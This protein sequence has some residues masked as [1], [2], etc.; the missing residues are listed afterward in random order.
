MLH[1]I[2]VS[3][4]FFIQRDGL[5]N[6]RGAAR[7]VALASL[8]S[9]FG[10]GNGMGAMLDSN[11]TTNSMIFALVD[12]CL[13]ESLLVCSRPCA[14]GWGDSWTHNVNANA[15]LRRKERES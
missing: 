7:G 11:D 14:W 3:V 2:Q 6:Q 9:H 4:P 12:S 5:K 1:F 10:S 8:R 13:A 15:G